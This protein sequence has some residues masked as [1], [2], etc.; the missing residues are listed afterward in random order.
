MDSLNR[1]LQ[2]LGETPIKK[3]HLRERKYPK[4]KVEKVTSAIK[5]KLNIS[6]EEEIDTPD[7]EMILY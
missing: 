1:S 2:V 5:R 4:A 6:S 3:K 7:S